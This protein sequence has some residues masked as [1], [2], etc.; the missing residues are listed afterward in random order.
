[1]TR[2]TIAQTLS[3]RIFEAM[4]LVGMLQLR[5]PERVSGPVA[6]R[7]NRRATE[8]DYAASRWQKVKRGR[9]S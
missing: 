6:V 9:I 8:K 4:I 5:N 7:Q 1:M 2:D 3:L